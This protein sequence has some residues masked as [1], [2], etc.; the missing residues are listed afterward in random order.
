MAID[1][2]T[3]RALDLLVESAALIRQELDHLA[4]L[5]DNQQAV[6]SALHDRAVNECPLFLVP[7]VEDADERAALGLF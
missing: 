1:R 6:I 2:Q 5:L 4:V 3:A 7:Q